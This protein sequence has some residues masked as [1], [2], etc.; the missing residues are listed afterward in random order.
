MSVPVSVI[1]TVMPVMIRMAEVMTVPAM[2]TVPAT[3]M[4]AMMIGMMR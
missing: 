4:V 3:M 1:P 2:M